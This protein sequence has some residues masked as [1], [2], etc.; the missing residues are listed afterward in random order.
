MKIQELAYGIA[1]TDSTEDDPVPEIEIV[2]LLSPGQSGSTSLYMVC[3]AVDGGILGMD[4]IVINF[5]YGKISDDPKQVTAHI[6]YGLKKIRKTFREP[7]KFLT[8]EHIKE[9]SDKV[10]EM[11]WPE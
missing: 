9:I 7:I 11:Y 1:V 8:D 3:A 4:D 2:I 10:Q 5:P 6:K